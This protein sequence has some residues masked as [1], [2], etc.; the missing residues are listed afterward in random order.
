TENIFKSI[1]DT[2]SGLDKHELEILFT[3]LPPSGSVS[4]SANI[5]NVLSPSS[6]GLTVPAGA[7]SLPMPGGGGRGSIM[8]KRDEITIID[9]KRSQAVNI[10]LARF[11]MKPEN[12]RDCLLSLDDEKIFDDDEK[13]SQLLSICPTEEEI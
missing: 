8:K 3:S 5:S 6:M 11:K 1:D 10:S 13:L 12:I 4:K 2:K 7:I 9:S